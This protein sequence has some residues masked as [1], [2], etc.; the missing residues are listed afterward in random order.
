VFTLDWTEEWITISVNGTVVANYADNLTVIQSFT[1]PQPLLITMTIME[2]TKPLPIDVFPQ[3]FYVDWVRIF[4]W[5]PTATPAPPAIFSA[6][7]SAP[8][9]VETEASLLGPTGSRV[10][11]P[12]ALWVLESEGNNSTAAVTPEKALKIVNNGSHCVL[13]VNQKFPASFDLRFGFIPQNV[14]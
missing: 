8:L 7:F 9:D 2:R 1:D 3:K 13:W 6:N 4:K 14:S 11:L 5:A 10:R 12:T